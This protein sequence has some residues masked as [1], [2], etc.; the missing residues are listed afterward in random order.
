[1][2]EQ[3]GFAVVSYHPGA[4]GD[5]WHIPDVVSAVY[6]E[7]RSRA[8]ELC[9]GRRRNNW[10]V[11]VIDWGLDIA[12]P[13]LGEEPEIPLIDNYRVRLALD[14]PV[15]YFQCQDDGADWFIVAVNLDH[16]KAILRRQCDAFGQEGVPFDQ[17]ELTWT[18][19][20]PDV[21]SQKLKCWRDDAVEP[22]PLSQCHL[23][24]TFCSEW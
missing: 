14:L 10:R 4:H 7:E 8:D 5:G 12:H 2:A 20:P 24:E 16:A 21:V 23:G 11:A 9:A 15:R 1:M 6:I 3:G 19:L 17:A 22:T 18:E 13:E